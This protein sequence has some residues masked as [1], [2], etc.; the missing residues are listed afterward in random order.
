MEL[1]NRNVLITG[2]NRGLGKALVYGLAAK[3][4]KKIY[5]G[6]RETDS[7]I[8]SDLPLVTP[9]QLDITN[10]VQ[11]Q[12]AT[13][14]A[15]DID[16]L[17]NNAGSLSFVSALNGSFELIEREIE[18]NFYGP[19]KMMR[20]F[21]P[22]LSKQ[23]KPAIVNVASIAS[24]VNFPAHGAYCASKAA[25]FSITQCARI[26]LYSQGI[27]VHSVNPG[28]IDTDM[29][30]NV[31]MQ[32]T[33]PEKTAEAILDGLYTDTPDIFPDEIG[34]NMFSLYKQDYTKLEELSRTMY[35]GH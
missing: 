32:K 2:S 12:Q 23:Q 14:I 4:V 7:K 21:I 18:V 9:V 3:G 11:I 13:R 24:F 5:A 31:A 10:D 28:P 22:I 25:A 1:K 8:F 15:A 17:F 16:L 27:A 35:R 6:M 26:E 33:S 30:K 20:A 34:A 29:T 19:L